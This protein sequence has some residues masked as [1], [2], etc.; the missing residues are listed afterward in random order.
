M[1]HVDFHV[2]FSREERR[3]RILRRLAE[4]LTPIPKLAKEYGVSKQAI[5]SMAR[6][7]E[8]RGELERILGVWPIIYRAGPTLAETII[9]PHDEKSPPTRTLP[10]TFHALQAK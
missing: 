6:R 1:A 2:D 8:I 5:Y 9:M 7:A 4:G 10:V 3:E